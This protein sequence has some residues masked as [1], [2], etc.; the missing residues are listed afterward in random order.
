MLFPVSQVLFS[1]AASEIKLEPVSPLAQSPQPLS[2]LSQ[3][4]GTQ[5]MFDVKSEIQACHPHPIRCS[6]ALFH[7]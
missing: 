2:P 1:I 4:N 5:P 7:I 6:V 3:Q